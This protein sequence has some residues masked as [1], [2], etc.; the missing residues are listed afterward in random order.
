MSIDAGAGARVRPAITKET[1]AKMK[2]AE[3]AE[4]DWQEVRRALS[5]S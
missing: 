5:G 1:L 2:P 4:L 3:I